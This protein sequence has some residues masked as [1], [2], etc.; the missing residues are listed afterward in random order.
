MES[1]S[2]HPSVTGLFHFSKMPSKFIHV[3]HMAEFLKELFFKTNIKI[4]LDYMKG[5]TWF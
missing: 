1:Y 2:I 4:N 5:N 3:S